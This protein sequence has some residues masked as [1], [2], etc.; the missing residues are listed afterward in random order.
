MPGR[1]KIR[2]R[3]RDVKPRFGK[4]ECK[5]LIFRKKSETAIREAI[6]KN[7]RLCATSLVFCKTVTTEAREEWAAS[8][9]RTLY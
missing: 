3:G 1:P 9:L 5:L 8:G 7:G 2:V 4:F 6:E